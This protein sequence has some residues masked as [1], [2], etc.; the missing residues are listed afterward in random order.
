MLIFTYIRVAGIELFHEEGQTDGERIK[1]T[2]GFRNCF[3]NAT[4]KEL[5]SCT[6]VTDW[7]L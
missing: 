7:S 5:S 3:A 2:A 4:K 6:A 1:L